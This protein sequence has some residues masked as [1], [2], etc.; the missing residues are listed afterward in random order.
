MGSNVTTMIKWLFIL[1]FVSAS[2]QAQI[3]ISKDTTLNTTWDFGDMTYEIAGQTHI[4]GKG[5][6]KG[7]YIKAGIFQ[8]IFDTT[9]TVSPKGVYDGKFCTSWFGAKPSNPDNYSALNKSIR[10][11]LDN[12]IINCYI[13][14]M[15]IYNY[16]QPL[17]IANIYKGNYVGATLHFYGSQ[18]FWDSNDR[19]VLNLTKA[20]DWAINLQ[21][22]KGSEIDHLKFTGQWTSPTGNDSAYYNTSYDDFKDVS[23][24]NCNNWYYGICI[25][26]K[27]NQNGNSNGSTGIKIHDVFISKFTH[28]IAISQSMTTLNAEI[29]SFENV[30]LG[31]GKTGILCDQA[32]EKENFIKGLYAWGRLH[33]VVS[34]G[35][36]GR[37]QAGYW[38]IDGVNI[39]G[40]VIR[41]FDLNASGWYP[42]HITNVY[43]ESLGTIGNITST[44]LPITI[45]KSVFHFALKADAGERLL[46]K[47]NSN[48]IKFSDCVFRYYGNT[49]DI[50]I[51]G[52]VTFDNC[53][54]SGNP[55][56]DAVPIYSNSKLTNGGRL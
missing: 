10:T 20:S 38:L 1:L 36:N 45:S 12:G 28:L 53:S 51:S 35:S 52:A 54:F 40:R 41:G 11:C 2:S 7:G 55:N 30:R 18:S 24:N 56:S 32:Q 21:L 49:D 29:L 27:S 48:S 15:G 37:K 6:L 22:N 13:P 47:T 42:T 19:C 33:T 17:E 16:S 8:D 4:S 9:L 39:A 44:N 31:D 3:V 5:T 43:A 25:D 50:K 14:P 34:I 23:G 26:R 46:L